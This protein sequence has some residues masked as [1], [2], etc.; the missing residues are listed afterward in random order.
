M[1]R[2]FPVLTQNALNHDLWEPVTNC[3]IKEVSILCGWPQI[4]IDVCMKLL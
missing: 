3:H 2:Y 1:H 4:N